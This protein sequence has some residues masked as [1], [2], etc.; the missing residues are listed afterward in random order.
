MIS[1]NGSLPII[2]VLILIFSLLLIS[3]LFKLKKIQRRLVKKFDIL[4]RDVDSIKEKK[5]H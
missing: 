5:E 1:S 2:S 3:E 4:R